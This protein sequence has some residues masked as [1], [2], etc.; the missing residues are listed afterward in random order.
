[1]MAPERAVRR[2]AAGV[3]GEARRGE[4]LRGFAVGNGVGC[5]WKPYGT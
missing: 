5:G 1:M 4:G 2:R 3:I